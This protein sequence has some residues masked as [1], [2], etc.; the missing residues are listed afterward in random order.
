MSAQSDLYNNFAIKRLDRGD[1]RYFTLNPGSYL[2]CISTTR[3]EPLDYEVGLV[4]EIENTEIELLLETGGTNK[5]VYE[6][7]LDLGNTLVIGPGFFVNYTLPT[8]QNGYTNTL[9]TVSTGVTVTIPSGS[10]WFI[11]NNTVS[12]SQ[13]FIL[14]DLTENYT[15]QDEHQ[16]S[17]SEWQQAW[18]RDHQQ[19]DR[20]PDVF[21]PLTTTS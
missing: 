16:H 17:L 19:D 3:N 12:A 21:I 5:F 11:D 18:Q 7:A 15:G 2:L 20:F 1:D 13:D 8:G 10:T 6:N 14:L 4:V 9:A